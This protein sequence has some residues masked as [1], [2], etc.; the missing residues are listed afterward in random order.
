M[1][2]F[3]MRAFD[4]GFASLGEILLTENE[5]L[6]ARTLEIGHDIGMRSGT[7]QLRAQFRAQN[8]D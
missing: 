8:V 2:G 6:F 3:K 4:T 5:H 1:Y 7:S